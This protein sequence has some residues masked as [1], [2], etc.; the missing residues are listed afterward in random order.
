MPVSF[1]FC[2]SLDF[3]GEVGRSLK[4]QGVVRIDFVCSRERRGS[5][6]ETGRPCNVVVRK[7]DH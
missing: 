2:V 7:A 5:F 1:R 6:S 3:G 4:R